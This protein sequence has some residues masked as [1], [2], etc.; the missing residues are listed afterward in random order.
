[1]PPPRTFAGFGVFVREDFLG[2]AMRR[3]LSAWM[4]TASGEAAPVH[5]EG[6][7]A[8]ETAERDVEEVD[9][10]PAL[11]AEINQRVAVLLP[12]LAV[13]FG[14]PLAGAEPAGFLRYG[15]GRFYRPHRDAS[16]SDGTA[17]RAV[18]VVVFVNGAGAA[19]EFA[20]GSLRLYGLLGDGPLGAIGLDLEPEAGVLIAFPSSWLHEVTPV[21]RGCRYSIVTWCSRPS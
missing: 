13:H 7:I 3:E 14:V 21:R 19:G 18:S 10:P 8:V 5:S 6:R 20:G 1:V 11:G 17:R 9:V 2:P 4:A 16:P 15:P 12:E